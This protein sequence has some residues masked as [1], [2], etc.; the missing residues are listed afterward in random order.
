MKEEEISWEKVTNGLW[1]I[2][3][4]GGHLY[5][6]NMEMMC[7]VP[8]V[9]LTRYQAHLRDA[10]NKGFEDGLIEGKAHKEPT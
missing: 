5:A 1:K 6:N 2:K 3:V 8:E 7:F 10:Y 4:E 9:D